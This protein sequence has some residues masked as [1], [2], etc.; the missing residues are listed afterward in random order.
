MGATMGDVFLDK[1]DR[2]I[3]IS[4]GALTGALDA[5]ICDDISLE[6]AHKWG[7][8]QVK[9]FV[10]KVAK[11]K[12]FKGKADDYSGAIDFLEEE[13]PIWAD[14]TTSAFGGG[15]Q[16]HLRDFSHHPTLLGLISSLVNEFTGYGFGTDTSGK[17]IVVKIEGWEKKDFLSAIYSGTINWVLHLISDIAG[18]SGSVRAG[19]E[20]TG[21]PGPLLSLI[22]EISSIPGIRSIGGVDKKGNYNFSVT[23]SK[24]FNGTLLG[25]HD[26]NGKILKDKILRFDLRTELGLIH[27]PI[28]TK[29]YIPVLLCEGIVCAFYSIRRLFEEIKEKCINTVEDLKNLDFS[30]FLPWNSNTL[31]RMRTISSI[32]FSSIDFSVAAIKAFAECGRNVPSFAMKLASGVNYF[33]I[34]RLMV[35]ARGELRIKTDKVYKEYKPLA[36][37]MQ[38]ASKLQIDPEVKDSAIKTISTVTT[39]AK[40]GTP[41]G[42]IAATMGVYKEISES[43]EEYKIAH[44]ERLKI[45]EE[46]RNSIEILRDYREEMEEVVTEYMFDRLSVFG[47]SLDK[48]DEALLSDDTDAFI[49]GNNAIQNKLGGKTVFSSQDEFDSL[50]LSDG[51]FKL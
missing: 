44:E 24:L 25:E 14:K 49:E 43:L 15:N 40:T 16:H 47:T 21:I 7:S 3:A 46:C 35:A 39:I 31:R 50:M 48:M 22:K 19:K 13:A 34:G 6:E 23:C 18:S 42:F 30:K 29:Q 2:I 33:G 51:V 5:L 28:R 41:I 36:I 9:E 10:Y 20:G 45:E 27:E 1:Y 32:T 12:G 4:S 38:K 11:R 8:D 26:E 37:A 17:F